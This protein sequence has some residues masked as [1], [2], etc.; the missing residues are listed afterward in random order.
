MELQL[1]Q[2]LKL[3]GNG[4]V[5]F[6]NNIRLNLADIEYTETLTVDSI[7]E[8]RP[9]LL[10]LAMYSTTMYADLILLYNNI[11]NPFYI[12]AGTILKVPN[13]NDIQSKILVHQ[14]QDAMIQNQTIVQQ[15]K[16]TAKTNKSSNVIRSD[17][18]LIF[19]KSNK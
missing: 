10:S 3:D 15:N 13:L 17:G 7:T 9:H 16:L 6:N 1:V 12:P 14:N 19:S 5:V 2:N 18:R 4:Y 8:H 11:N